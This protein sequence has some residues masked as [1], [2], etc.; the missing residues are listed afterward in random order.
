M[1]I[2]ILS[3]FSF[4][5]ICIAVGV[6]AM[7]ISVIGKIGDSE[8][9]K[10][11]RVFARIY[12]V[13]IAGYCVMP[14]FANNSLLQFFAV[15]VQWLSFATTLAIITSILAQITGCAKRWVSV[16]VA[17]YSYIALLMLFVELIFDRYRIINNKTGYF[18]RPGCGYLKVIYLVEVI[19]FVVSI[20]TLLIR[21]FYLH[22]RKRERYILR[23][24][25]CAILPAVC[26]LI[27][28]VDLS[29]SHRV[30]YPIFTISI[31]IPFSLFRN[32]LFIVR[33]NEL[34]IE[35]FEEELDP[36]KTDPVLICD[37]NQRI[38]F[39]NNATIVGGEKKEDII[40]RKIDDIFFI[41][42]EL[43]EYILENR[44]GEVLSIPAIYLYTNERIVLKIKHDFDC[45]GEILSS[46]VTGTDPKTL[47]SDMFNSLSDIYSDSGAEESV[48]SMSLNTLKKD[49]EIIRD[50]SILIV[51]EDSN[52]LAFFKKILSPYGLRIEEALGGDAALGAIV[53]PKYDLIIISYD[54]K[55]VSGLD[56]ARRIRLTEGE[57]YKNVPIVFCISDNIEDIYIDLLEVNFNDYISRPVS[58]RQLNLVLTRW[59]WKRYSN[60]ENNQIVSG[61][62]LEK[63][64]DTALLDSDV[65]ERRKYYEN[66]KNF[67][68]D[69]ANY[70][71]EESWT[72]MG[73]TLHGLR[74]I[75][76][77][78]NEDKL[79]EMVNNI[80]DAISS[81]DYSVIHKLFMKL[82]NDVNEIL[83]NNGLQKIDIIRRKTDKKS[84]VE[85]IVI[86]YNK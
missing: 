71:N 85:R 81:E 70:Y 1:S 21:Y 56:T 6:A 79:T 19:L 12:L 55:I 84:I 47:D 45:V 51:S 13:A 42:N 67:I 66:L 30:F 35:D 78:L 7:S 50:A 24:S 3:I 25:L 80:C 28:Q 58:T 38:I 73:C 20:L 14:A 65:H 37:D 43:K 31:I 40:F 52:E 11:Y 17:S 77:I 49:A 18:V 61:L 83:E 69:A 4:I 2:S 53:N 8:S 32:L 23:M 76:V 82:C 86:R 36:S 15:T 46:T 59:L 16:V 72:L 48:Y 64:N 41:S 10:K 39:A 9:E 44:D 62:F 22:K 75:S 27:M 63:T 74:R 68:D 60:D 33:K 34:H 54:M 57:Y 29:V 26:A 5:L